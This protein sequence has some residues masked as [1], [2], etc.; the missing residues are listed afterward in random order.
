METIGAV[1]GWFVVSQTSVESSALL[2]GIYFAIVSG[3]MVRMAFAEQIYVA[4]KISPSR[5][6][7]NIF[8][9][10]LALMNLL[11]IIITICQPDDSKRK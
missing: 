9:G 5:K 6:T 4:I 1:F 7:H 2:P 10:S 8:Y 3:V 11:F